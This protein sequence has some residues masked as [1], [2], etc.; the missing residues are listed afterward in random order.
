[1]KKIYLIILCS[2]LFGFNSYAQP[3]IRPTT[4]PTA[5]RLTDFFANGSIGGYFNAASGPASGYLVIA[6]IGAF[7]GT[8]NDGN[9]YTQNQTIGNG[10]VVQST[11]AAILGFT[12]I[13]LNGNTQYT[14]T[15]FS[16]NSG[17][18]TGGP[19]YNTTSPPSVSGRSCTI[20]P[21]PAAINRTTTSA[22]I[23]WNS[24]LGGGVLA[25]TYT[26]DVATDNGFT[27]P[28]PGS[29][30]TVNDPTISRNILGLTEASTY[31]FRV[32]ATGSCQTST[33]YNFVTLC[34]STSTP[35]IQNFDAAI[36]PNLPPCSTIEDLN[37]STTWTTAAAP[38]G[39]T[40]KV[41]K[42]TNSP[43]LLPADDWFYT[44]GI[45][46]TAGTSYTI[47]YK[48]GNDSANYVDNGTIE[49]MN[50]KYGTGPNSTAMVNLLAD[51]L[52]IGSTNPK[53]N[54]VSF[55]PSTTAIYYFGFHA[56]SQSGNYFLY[57]DS[58]SVHQTGVL[59]VTIVSFNA[60]RNGAENN[61]TWSTSQ[62]VNTEHFIVEHSTDGHN[63]NSIGKVNAIGNNNTTRN[64]Q[65][66]DISPVKALNYYR[67]GIVDR[68]NAIK[69]SEV[70]HVKNSSNADFMIY[71][72]P[73]KDVIKVDINT[74]TAD[75][76]VM[77]LTDIN[78]MDDGYVAQHGSG[79]Y[80]MSCSS[81][82]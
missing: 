81:F 31:F 30:F 27:S 35:Y 63:F 76:G 51:H 21:L 48:Y 5:L 26:L 45:N 54:A 20:L 61:I 57:L 49:S 1:M 39:Y 41:L 68:D 75:K 19:L 23:N 44:Q 8:L 15:V 46:L 10:K 50:I 32:N 40:G 82:C 11:D 34:S 74:D 73:A 6:S 65:F 58:I 43:V 70:R 38:K 14:I 17:T 59:P 66:N 47:G 67:L 72:N 29:P 3:C 78:G 13:N 77:I 7:T 79:Y 12:A 52:Q 9:N 53:T 71:P 22:T 69:F 18:C 42:Y 16:Y 24:S 4:Q 56:Y 33:I 28:I 64:Y 62:E 55:I 2:I 36:V 37:G 60:K 25:I 80:V